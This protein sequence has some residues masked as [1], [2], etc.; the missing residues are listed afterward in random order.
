MSYI[1]HT[2]TVHKTASLLT[3][4]ILHIVSLAAYTTLN[5]YKPMEI[6]I[7]RS[8]MNYNVLLNYK[9]NENLLLVIFKE[10]FIKNQNKYT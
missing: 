3:K 2:S 7:E 5:T 8:L 1:L 4:A 9:T 6:S 10:L